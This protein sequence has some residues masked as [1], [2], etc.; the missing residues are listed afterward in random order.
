MWHCERFRH[1]AYPSFGPGA[2]ESAE[3]H[4]AEQQQQQQH[5][6]HPQSKGMNEGMDFKRRKVSNSYVQ[7]TW[8][9]QLLDM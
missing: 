4:V 7:S 5:H 1:K 6:T 9:Q 3:T 8:K 2:G